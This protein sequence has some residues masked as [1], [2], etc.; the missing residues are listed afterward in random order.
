MSSVNLMVLNLDQIWFRIQ[1][2]KIQSIV[3]AIP[4]RTRF[5]KRAPIWLRFTPPIWWL[6][7]SDSLPIYL[8][9]DNWV[10]LSHNKT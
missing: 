8:L 4:L 7:T 1:N 5:V 3:S 2:F 6:T 9:L 10:P